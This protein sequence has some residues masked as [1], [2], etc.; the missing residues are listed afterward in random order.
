MVLRDNQA[1]SGIKLA[2]VTILE[3]GSLIIYPMNQLIKKVLECFCHWT[4]LKALCMH[5]SFL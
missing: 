1:Y 2:A 4:E 5:V 3:V